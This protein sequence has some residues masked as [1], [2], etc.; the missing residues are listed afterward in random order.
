MRLFSPSF[1]VAMLKK[2][3]ICI[4][5]D[6]L[7]V[8]SD[9]KPVKGCHSFFTCASLIF[10]SSHKKQSMEIFSIYLNMYTLLYIEI[11]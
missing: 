2:N 3:K 5:A 6:Y 8:K 4:F 1:L 10:I 7:L 9:R 11:I